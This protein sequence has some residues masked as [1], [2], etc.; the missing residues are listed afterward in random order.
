[1]PCLAQSD[2]DPRVCLE[3]PWGR[4]LGEGALGL[5]GGWGWDTERSVTQGALNYAGVFLEEAGAW[6]SL[7]SQPSG[8]PPQP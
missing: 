3:G 6:L 4:G 7:E 8:S 1:M 5:G 2:A